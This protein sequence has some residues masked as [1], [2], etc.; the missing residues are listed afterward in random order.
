MDYIRNITSLNQRILIDPS[1]YELDAIYVSALSQRRIYLAS[2]GYAVQ[3]GNFPTDKFTDLQ[4]FFANPVKSYLT[5]NKIDYI[6]LLKKG[7]SYR[8]LLKST[9]IG[10]KIIFENKSVIIFSEITK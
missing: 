7:N 2:Q 8:N 3:T 9:N 1:Q 4:D 10:Q 6:Y 5:N